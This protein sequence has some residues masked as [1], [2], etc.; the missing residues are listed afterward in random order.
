[1]RTVLLTAIAMLA[2]ATNSVLARLALSAGDIDPLAFTGIRLT[3]GAMVLAAIFSFRSGSIAKSALTKTANWWGALSLVAYA[4]TFS[5]AYVIVGA[6]PGALILFASVQISMVAWAVIKGDRPALL[7]WLGM[8]VAIAALA[9]LVSPGL[10]APP[11]HGAI[12]MAI[13]GVSWGA[14]SL[15][16]RGSVSPL[17]DTAGNFILCAPVA[18]GLIVVGIC[19]L[20]PSTAGL[21]YAIASGAVASGLGYVI[22]YDVLPKL[23]R[24]TAAVVQLTVPVIAALGGV[25][26]IGEPL[27][28]R[29]LI[30]MA[31]ISGGVLLSILVADRRRRMRG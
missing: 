5:V 20:R 17:A 31:G 11:L 26:L 13:A 4:V 8:G 19:T 6:G 15:L 18:L 9:Y 23:S 22:W 24:T 29:L 30:A 3:A 14:Y 1:M 27:T 16:G 2:F 21:A 10:A 28:A 12:L 7:E 25:A